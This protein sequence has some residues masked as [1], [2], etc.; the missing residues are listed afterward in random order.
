MNMKRKILFFCCLSLLFASCKKEYT[1]ITNNTTT[2]KVYESNYYL[3]NKMEKV[4]EDIRPAY[5]KKGDTVAVFA[6]SNAV[7]ES[8]VKRGIATLEG[9]GLKVILADNL[10]DT[11]GRYAG[12][13]SARIDGLQA[14]VDNASVRAIIAARGGFGASQIIPYIDLTKFWE[15]PKW[16]VGFSDLTTFHAALNN[17]GMESIHGAMVNN[18]TDEESVSTLHDALFGTLRKHTLKTNRYCIEGSAEGRLVGGN[19]SIIYSL[20]GTLYDLNTRDAILLIE[21]TG[22]SNYHIERMMINLK[23]S[24]KLDCVKGVVI[25]EF[26]KMTQGID[27]SIEEIMCSQLQS[28]GIPVLYGINI[29]HGD[30]NIATYLGRQVRLEVDDDESSI[31]YLE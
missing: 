9:W 29:G 28:L 15:S 23:L 5:L 21:D 10:Y 27:D 26:T 31:T 2:E 1:Y 25:G 7:S 16:M 14:L 30:V 17:K 11:D 22:E 19:L 13:Q 8:E 4:T 18:M 20:G 3:D 24:G 12:T 6:I